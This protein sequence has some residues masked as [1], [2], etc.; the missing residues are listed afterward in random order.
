MGVVQS[1]LTFGLMILIQT[2]AAVW[3]VSAIRTELSSHGR[4]ILGLREWRHAAAKA[5]M[6]VDNHEKVVA[7][8]EVRLRAVESLRGDL[9]K[10]LLAIETLRI[11]RQYGLA[12]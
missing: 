11:E 5:L 8:H 2:V 6:L 4:E 9:E 3:M 7:D 1:W 10:K 12:E